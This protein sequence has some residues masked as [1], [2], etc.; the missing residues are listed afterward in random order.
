MTETLIGK[1]IKLVDND[2]EAR[3]T[4]FSPA[5][6]DDAG[7]EESSS[8]F[9]HPLMTHFPD[10][11]ALAAAAA[12]HR[13]LV[14]KLINSNLRPFGHHLLRTANGRVSDMAITFIERDLKD[15]RLAIGRRPLRPSDHAVAVFWTRRIGTPVVYTAQRTARVNLEAGLIQN[16]HRSATIGSFPGLVMSWEALTGAEPLRARWSPT[17][18]VIWYDEEQAAWLSVYSKL[19]ELSA[20]S[21]AAE[22]YA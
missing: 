22:L 9:D 19:P 17:E 11:R 1:H 10:L 15:H 7:F 18:F 20:L 4:E 14:P 12:P 21:V 2:V 16:A 3:L 13:V 8:Y 6:V 5:A